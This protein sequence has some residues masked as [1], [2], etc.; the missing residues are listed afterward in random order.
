MTLARLH[1]NRIQQAT[2]EQRSSLMASWPN[3]WG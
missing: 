3:G 1:E 2:R